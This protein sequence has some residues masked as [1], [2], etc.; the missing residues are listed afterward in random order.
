MGATTRKPCQTWASDEKV[1]LG[2]LP[3]PSFD[4]LTEPVDT[5]EF[6]KLYRV[7]PVSNIHLLNI[8][9]TLPPQEKNYSVVLLDTFVSILSL[10]L[11][12]PAYGA[13]IAKLE[14]K[15]VAGEHGLVIRVKG[16]NRK[17]PMLAFLLSAAPVC[18]HLEVNGPC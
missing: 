10:N 9:W 13:D 7:I 8:T 17:I 16:L 14:Y 11:S 6:H 1:F 18:M 2:G 15:L 4:H 5:P 3:N 12:E